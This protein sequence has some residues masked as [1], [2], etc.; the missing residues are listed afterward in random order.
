[1]SLVGDERDPGERK[2]LDTVVVLGVNFRGQQLGSICSGAQRNF[3]PLPPGGS[4][5]A[6]PKLKGID[7]RAPPEVESA[8][9]FD[10][11]RE[12]SQAPKAMGIVRPKVLLDLV[13]SGAWPFLVRELACQ[14]NC[15]NERDLDY[16]L[17]AF[18]LGGV[19]EFFPEKRENRKKIG[20]LCVA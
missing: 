7:G 10:S 13:K 16:F 14:L 8:A 20:P 1:M 2:R 5:V 15:L 19:W 3:K 17:P 6:R 12:N 18:P 9:Q 4:I 11:T